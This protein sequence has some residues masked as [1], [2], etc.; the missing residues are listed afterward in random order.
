[1]SGP[2][3]IGAHLAVGKGLEHT[4]DE[5]VERGLEALQL[6]LRNPRGSRA[7]QFREEELRYFNVKM[8]NNAIN[9]VVAHVPYTCNPAAAKDRIYRYALQV[10]MEDL[11]RCQLIN[12]DYLVLHPGSYTTS[13]PAEG[14]ERISNLLNRVLFKYGGKTLILLETMSGQG[15]EIGGTFDELDQILRNVE[16]Q[17]KIGICFDTCHTYAAGYDCT[18]PEGISRILRE[19]DNTFGREKVKLVHANDSAKGLGSRRDR[20]AHIGEGFIGEAGFKQLFADAFFRRLP[21]ILETPLDKL[22]QDLNVLKK[23]R[24]SCPL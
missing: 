15:T 17:D 6:F 22:D 5:A 7:R 18:T 23:I 20:H 2:P 9:P 10:I 24:E 8:Q 11:E 19:M 21:F 12:A 16:N 1:M 4:A 13:S 14:I 3:C